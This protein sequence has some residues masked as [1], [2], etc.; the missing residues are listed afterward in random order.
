MD[1]LYANNAVFIIES[2]VD[3]T[4]GLPSK[5]SSPRD[6]FFGKCI[7]YAPQ[8]SGYDKKFMNN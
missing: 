8:R 5:H 1:N 7:E 6:W 3:T 4:K 2:M